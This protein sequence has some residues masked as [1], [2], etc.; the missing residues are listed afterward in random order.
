MSLGTALFKLVWGRRFGDVRIVRA[1]GWR[2]AIYDG[3]GGQRIHGTICL[4]PWDCPE[5]GRT[6]RL[7]YTDTIL[8]VGCWMLAM[9]LVGC[10]HVHLI[11]GRSQTINIYRSDDN[12][13]DTAMEAPSDTDVTDT[14]NPVIPVQVGPDELPGGGGGAPS[15]PPGSEPGTP[16]VPAPTPGQP[17]EPEEPVVVPTDQDL[18]FLWKPESESD[19]KLV[20]LLPWCIHAASVSAHNPHGEWVHGTLSGLSNTIRETWRFGYP[21]GGWS[22]PNVPVRV[23]T[24]DGEELTWTVP[25]GGQRYD[26]DYDCGD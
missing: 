11:G 3:R 18:K 12:M 17:D 10:I 21:G 16:N 5:G 8:M 25:A 4:F 20:I 14:L 15:S 26:Q 9:L 2:T 19:G 7:K 6:V 22:N 13:T 24:L 23:I 1:T